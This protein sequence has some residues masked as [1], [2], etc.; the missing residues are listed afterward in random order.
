M[1][2]PAADRQAERAERGESPRRP[3]P[4]L[5]PQGEDGRRYF[6]ASPGFLPAS[7]SF[8]SP[9]SFTSGSSRM[10]RCCQTLSVIS[11]I[12]CFTSAA[13]ARS[14][15]TMKQLMTEITESV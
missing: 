7:H 6:F 12:N 5:L 13:V 15:L 14:T 4:N 9:T 10:A 11:V 2:N 8:H 1:Q 3:H